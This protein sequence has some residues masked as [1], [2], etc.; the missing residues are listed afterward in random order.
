MKVYCII[1]PSCVSGIEG[2]ISWRNV[3]GMTIEL[4]NE[5][6]SKIVL[7]CFGFGVLVYLFVTISSVQLVI[8]SETKCNGY[9]TMSLKQSPSQVPCALKCRE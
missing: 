6:P 9:K 8:T 4:R 1:L 5:N 7:F 3:E 2:A